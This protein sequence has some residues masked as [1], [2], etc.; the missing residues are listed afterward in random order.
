MISDVARPSAGSFSW[1][2]ATGGAKEGDRSLSF[3]FSTVRST[4]GGGSGGA[5]GAAGAAGSAG[6]ATARARVSLP[7]AR[8]VPPPSAQATEQ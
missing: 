4:I 3:S 8:P 1:A 5:T 7:A 2:T 6:G